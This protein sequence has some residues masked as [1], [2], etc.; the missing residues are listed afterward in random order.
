MA[1][2]VGVDLLCHEVCVL[3][4]VKLLLFHDALELLVM[5]T[6]LFMI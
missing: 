5:L 1:E 6:C 2:Y 4:L 3:F